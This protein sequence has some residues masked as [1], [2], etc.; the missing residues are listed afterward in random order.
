GLLAV[1]RVGKG[2]DFTQNE[3]D[4]LASLAQQTAIA[5]E[6]ARLF[7]DVTSSQSQLSEALRI[8]RIGYFEYDHNTEVI[9]VTN[10]LLDLVGTTPE[11]EGG[12]QLPVD[13]IINKFVV[14]YDR[15]LLTQ[16]ISDTLSAREGEKD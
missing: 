5:I 13:H 1:W 16:A 9:T 15:R 8:A 12:H 11:K 14:P 4:F 6:N 2:T 10:E 7:E 3:F